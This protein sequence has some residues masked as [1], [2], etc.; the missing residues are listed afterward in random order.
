MFYILIVFLKH[1]CYFYNIY[2]KKYMLKYKMFA[3][4]LYRPWQ[5]I[6]VKSQP[7]QHKI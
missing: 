6:T 7:N 4:K 3:H 5:P 1:L 2:E